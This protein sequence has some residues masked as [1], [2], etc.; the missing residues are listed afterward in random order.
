M[1]FYVAT[2][3]ENRERA[4][5]V[6]L[7]LCALGH[8]PAYDWTLHGD[9]RNAGESR[10]NEVSANEIAAVSGAELV[11]IL[12]PGG[13]GT[14]IELG[15]ALATCDNKRIVLWSESAEAFGGGTATCV[16]YHHPAVRHMCCDFESLYASLDVL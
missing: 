15:T 16:F 5:K 1:T 6:I 4:A 11:L 10:M 12:L 14:H 7:R 9:V 8:S 3:L 2:G 13:K